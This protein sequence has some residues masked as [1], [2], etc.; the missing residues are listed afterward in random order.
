MSEKKEFYQIYPIGYV[1]SVEDG[2]RLEIS[3]PFR[4]ELK[5]LDQF[6]HVHVIWWAESYT[7]R[8]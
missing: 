7:W 8:G 6:S 2:F 4:P 1:H 5:H 3:E